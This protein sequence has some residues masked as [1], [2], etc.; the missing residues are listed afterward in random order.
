MKRGLD[1]RCLGKKTAVEIYH[2]QKTSE[3]ADRL[4]RR[5]ELEISDSFWE[6][7]RTQGYFVSQ[8]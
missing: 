2:S 6:R 8:E 7:L 4:G 3:L 1:R 5:R